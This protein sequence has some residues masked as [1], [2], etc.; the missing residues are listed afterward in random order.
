MLEWGWGTSKKET[1][2]GEAGLWCVLGCPTFSC[3]Q[4]VQVARLLMAAGKLAWSMASRFLG[5][6]P[7][8]LGE[9]GLCTGEEAQE[10]EPRGVL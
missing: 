9:G 5:Y 7:L 6:G 8:G 4:P 1:S 10:R 2:V 3:N